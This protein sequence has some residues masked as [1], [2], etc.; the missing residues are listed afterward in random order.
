MKLHMLSCIRLRKIEKQIKIEKLRP[1]MTQCRVI[2]VDERLKKS[3]K[4]GVNK[5]DVV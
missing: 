4:Q 1:E 2:Q 5:K 3:E